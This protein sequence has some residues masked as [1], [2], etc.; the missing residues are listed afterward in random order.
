MATEDIVKG[1]PYIPLPIDTKMLHKMRNKH[2]LRPANV[3]DGCAHA[4][5][6]G[7]SEHKRTLTFPW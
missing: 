3:V 4:L 5:N 2:K 7:N 6:K 1:S